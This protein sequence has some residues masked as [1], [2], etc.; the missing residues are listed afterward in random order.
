M[1]RAQ[2]DGSTRPD[3]VSALFSVRIN[4]WPVIDRG[5]PRVDVMT[6]YKWNVARTG[7]LV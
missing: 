7:I 4:K 5:G 1:K 2:P 3:D 6:M